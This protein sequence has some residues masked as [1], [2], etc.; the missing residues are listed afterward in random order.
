MIRVKALCCFGFAKIIKKRESV[1]YFPFFMCK[2]E[3]VFL[4]IESI[5]E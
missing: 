4:Y 3:Y 5:S 2:T 1:L